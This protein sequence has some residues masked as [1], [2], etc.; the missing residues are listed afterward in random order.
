MKDEIRTEVFKEWGQRKHES[1][2]TVVSRK[3]VTLEYIQMLG[4]MRM[5]TAAGAMNKHDIGRA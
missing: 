3:S 1:I 4:V 2:C 5:F